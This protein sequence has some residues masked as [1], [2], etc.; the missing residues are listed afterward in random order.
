[1]GSIRIEKGNCLMIAHRGL[2]G[3]E[4]ENTASSFVAAGNRSYFGIETDVHVTRDGQYV[5]CHDD[6]L[7]RVAGVDISVEGSTLEELCAVPLYDA[8]G[9]SRTDLFVPTLADYITICRRYDKWAVLE[10]KN[11]IAPEHITGILD[12]IRSYGWLDKTVFISFVPENLVEVRRQEPTA[13]AQF[14]PSENKEWVFRFA[15][16]NRLDLDIYHEALTP[17]MVAMAHAAGL[18]VNCWTVDTPEAAAR[19]MAMG[20][21]F[22]TTNILE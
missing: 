14:L 21:D 2:S 8:P 22:I 20:V 19:V 15:V 7:R 11:A 9:G 5:I 12:V 6:D 4:P 13:A 1:M 10:L 16:E 18:R 17:E 3:V